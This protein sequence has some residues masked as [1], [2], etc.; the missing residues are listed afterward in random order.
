VQLDVRRSP[1]LTAAIGVMVTMPREAAK[2][3]RKYS[4]SVIQPEWKKG[5]SGRAPDARM[6]QKRLVGGGAAYIRDNGVTLVAGKGEWI[7]QTEFGGR[8]N[9]YATYTRKNRG[10]GGSHTVKRRTLR[11][12][13]HW[14]PK[15]YVVYPMAEEMIPRIA[16]LWVQTIYR[17]VAEVIEDNVNG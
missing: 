6:F 12:F 8:R 14:N 5:L 4:K 1:S 13:W 11:Q 16:S 9:M 3:T 17:T 2:A 7:R 10:G 15:G